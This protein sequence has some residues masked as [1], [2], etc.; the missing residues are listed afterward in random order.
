MALMEE[1]RI[2]SLSTDQVQPKPAEKILDLDSYDD[3]EPDVDSASINLLGHEE[4]TSPDPSAEVSK[5]QPEQIAGG[6]KKPKLLLFALT[7]LVLLGIGT[8]SYLLL[9]KQEATKTVIQPS[10]KKDPITLPA[11]SPG[12]SPAT[13][14]ATPP[15]TISTPETVS[16]PAIA[17]TTERPQSVTIQSKSGLWLRSSPDSSNRNNIISWIPNGAVVSVDQVGDFWWHGSYKGTSGYFASKY[18]Q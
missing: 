17:P 10:P 14:T 12:P 11:P 1:N 6:N 4:T 15:P 7:A 8:G 5:E 9:P 16:A 3:S 2:D 13:P 18:T